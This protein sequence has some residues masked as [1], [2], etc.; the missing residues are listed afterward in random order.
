MIN[1]VVAVEQG[2]GIG[3]NG[4][5]PW[6]HLRGDMKWFKELTTNQ[7]VIMGSTTWKSLGKRLPNRVNM[8]IGRTPWDNSDHCYLTPADALTS[9]SLLYPD[10]E[11][12]IIGGQALYDSMMHLVDR[13][14]VTE[15]EQQYQ[16]DKFFNLT[17]VQTNFPNIKLH[18]EHNDPVNYKIKEYTK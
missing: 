1:C 15:I 5:M 11:V 6:P 8:I 16:C 10:K 3:Y 17:H 14:Y 9:C 13:F 2:Q 4:S 18:A 12:F 7:V